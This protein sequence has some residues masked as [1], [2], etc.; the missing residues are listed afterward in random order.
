MVPV[1]AATGAAQPRG[2]T[3]MRRMHVLAGIVA[4]VLAASLLPAH[5]QDA[6]LDPLMPIPGEQA[7][8]PAD[9][10]LGT[11]TVELDGPIT[12]GA[13]ADLTLRVHAQGDLRHCAY[14]YLVPGNWV[15]AG[16]F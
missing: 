14:E 5:A 12:T 4:A 9:L 13:L 3:P 6:P 1:A 2:G 10:E 8:I 16:S 15:T 7:H 11:R